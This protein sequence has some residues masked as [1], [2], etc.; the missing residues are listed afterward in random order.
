MRTAS[1]SRW[2]T[3]YLGLDLRNLSV[4]TRHRKLKADFSAAPADYERLLAAHE[5]IHGPL[6]SRATLDLS[7]GARGDRGQHILPAVANDTNPK[8]SEDGKSFPRLR[9]GLV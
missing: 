1:A 4:R 6:F 2:Y 9:F 8:R 5:T 3:A 7:G